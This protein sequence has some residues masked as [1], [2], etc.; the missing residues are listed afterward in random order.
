MLR[1]TPL[2][3]ILVGFL[4]VVLGWVLP[5]L[6][7][8]G[9]IKTGFLLSFLSYGASVAGLFVGFIGAAMYVRTKRKRD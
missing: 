9:M 4:L 3:M 2:Q 5:F 6:M 8:M 1:L 7:V